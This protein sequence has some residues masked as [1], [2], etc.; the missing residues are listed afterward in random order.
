MKRL[1]IKLWPDLVIVFVIIWAV[2]FGGF[3][4]L[5][6]WIQIPTGAVDIE[7]PILGERTAQIQFSV[8]DYIL[9]TAVTTAT[10]SID[11]VKTTSA[12]IIDFMDGYD[13]LT[14]ATTPDQTNVYFS[15]GDTVIIHI[16]CTGNPSNGLD[17]YDG[18]FIFRL[19]DGAGVYFFEPSMLS[20]VTTNPWTYRV[21]NLVGEATG[22]TV[23][24][25]SGTTN[26]W[27]IGEVYLYPRSAETDVDMYL[28]YETVQLADVVATTDWIDTDAE[29]TANGT[30]A[31][32]DEILKLE[33]LHKNANLGWGWPIY[34]VSSEGELRTHSA[35]AIFTTTMTAIG[36]AKLATYG[37]KPVSWPTLYAEVGFYK[38]IEPQYSIKGYKHTWV[39]EI[40]IEAS[41]AAGSTAFLFK[42][43]IL[44]IQYE[45]NVAIGQTSVTSP[46]AYGF[47]T[48]Y[49][50][51]PAVRNRAMTVSSGASAT[52]MIRVHMTTN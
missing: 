33:V 37:W 31:S 10:T 36:S 21:N 52:E 47:I 45:G 51:D 4:S 42:I 19:Q 13:T 24:F 15:E 6:G 44:D 26:Y 38:V 40:P 46:T 48:D 14:V 17:Y 25:T 22:Y 49:G 18:W 5:Q 43:S 32:D 39:L 11:F 1:K 28:T 8:K 29:I 16:D 27:D 3:A 9:K 35:I 30:L 20:T 34:V 50:P 12:G 23:S 41:A 7:E 2:F